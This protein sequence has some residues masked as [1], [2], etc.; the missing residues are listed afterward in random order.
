MRWLSM[1]FTFL[2]CVPAWAGVVWVPS[3]PLLG[4][5]VTPSTVRLYVDDGAKIRVK[6]DAGKV[7]PAVAGAD[8]VWTIPYTPPRVAAV[9]TVVFR[10]SVGGGETALDIP[11]VPPFTGSIGL[12]FDPPVLPSTG[13]AMIKIAPEGSTAVAA[14][15][16]SFLLVAS[17]GTVDTVTPAGNGVW[18]ARYTPPKGLT[19]PLSVVFAAADAAAPDK[20]QGSAVLPVT[21]KR[22]V[23]FDVKPGS[24]N[25]M[26]VGSR[27]YGPIVAAPT[28][29]VAFDIDLDPREPTGDLRS[30]NPD[31]SKE[32]REAPLPVAATTAIAFYPLPASVP[33]QADLSVPVRIMVIGPDG[34]PKADATVKLSASKG[35]ITP[36]TWDRDVFSATFSPPTTPGEV[37]LFAEV[38]GAKSERKIKIVGTIPTLTLSTEP[39][40][41]AKAGTSFSVIARVKDAQGTGVVGRAPTLTVEGATANGSA[42]DNKD[43]S[44]TFPFKVSSSTNRVRVY[45][46]PPVETSSM[47]A[48]RLVAWPGAATVA[49]NGT[50]T[51]TVTVLAVDAFGL[52]V[53]NVTLK[54]GAPRGDGSVPP[55]G[56][57]DA[58]GMA[59]VTFTA[60]RAPGV[61]S[62]RIEAAGL[63]TEVP[64]FQTK[65]GIGPI[66]PTGG[67][68]AD[69]ALVAKWK[70]AAP[71]LRIVR[72]GVV[73]PSGPPAT[74]QITT[75]PPYTTPGA[76]ILVNIRVMDSAGSGV[77]GK[78]LNISA[79]PAVVGQIT[80]N[81]DGSY[82]VPLQLP[83]G[84]DG[85]IVLT[86]G[87]DSA[88]GS[89]TLP[90]LATVG[91]QQPT[92]GA[93]PAGGLGR[94]KPADTSGNAAVRAPAAP[95]T[96]EWAKLRF[97][98]GLLNARGTYTMSSDAGAQLLGAA[99][100]ATPG[101]GFFGLALE[102][103]WLPFHQS[104]G[105]LGLDVRG[106]SQIEWFQVGDWPFINVQRDAIVAARYRRALNGLFSVEGTLGAHYTT[107]VLFRYSDAARTDAEL[108]NFPL[109]G[110]RLG[111]LV[112]L[113]SEA[114]YVSLELAETFAP[115]PIDTHAELMVDL[116]ISDRGTTLRAGG[117]W[118]Y[119]S[120]RYAAEGEAGDTGSASVQQQQFTV[121]LGAGQVF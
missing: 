91:A 16:R 24:S 75:V 45:A 22:S 35:T 117:S 96:S 72:E 115:F 97:G 7:G 32:D 48:A 64:L 121:R 17:A 114:I 46:A 31:T 52:P 18:V 43:G 8:G 4:D 110:A 78:K 27:T 102:G 107:G 112:S 2:W 57:T 80:D 1:L 37:V 101:A 11:V 118:D 87:V 67:G 89:V 76:A 108:L 10:V 12:T 69:E 51:V 103:V 5:G 19:A 40:E 28:G 21:V 34:R 38:D 100:F 105:S 15:G 68:T 49:A 65:D 116:R 58:R 26:K 77:G 86:V 47:P 54:L 13:T 90:T 106:R 92:S 39:A 82:A 120:M 3:P 104:W 85:P 59:R 63:V 20:V 73:P 94:Q 9:G 66:L 98:G 84:T 113:E 36:A 44:Y 111:A 79:G 99:S 88:A 55:T 70:A 30:V 60:G 74:V 62:V 119:R 29:K 14:E 42:K 23:S 61:A 83:A 56:K 109:F 81:R 6:A 93:A 95:V 25:V 53:P 33:A 41:I 71:E 50:D